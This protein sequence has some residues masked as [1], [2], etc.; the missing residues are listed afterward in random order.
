M[1][2]S[3]HYRGKTLWIILIAFVVPLVHACP[4][5][6]PVLFNS[7]NSPE[8]VVLTNFTVRGS[9]LGT[10]S[11]Y[12]AADR[13]TTLLY[14]QRKTQVIDRSQ[15]NAWMVSSGFS[16]TYAL[17]RQDLQ[18]MADTLNASVVILGLVESSAL[19][20]EWPNRRHRVSVTLRMLCGKSA[21]VLNIV[22]RD[23]ESD[24]QPEMV[25]NAIL[26]ELVQEI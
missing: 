19:A 6:G 22:H 18:L 23:R 8:T 15:I 13:L 11:G 10:A 2:K 16:H 12:K 25:I 7:E 14:E 26:E 20:V 5:A 1:I 24:Q 17:A 4:G 3:L 9:D 21:K